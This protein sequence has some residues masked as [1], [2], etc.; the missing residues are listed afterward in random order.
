MEVMRLKFAVIGGDRRAALLAGLLLREGE[1]VQSFALEKAALPPE[2]PR[3]SSPEAALYGADAVLLPLPVERGGLLNAP[4]SAQLC[5]T[6]ELFELLWPGQ[7][8]CGGLIPASLTG[9]AAQRGL[10]PVDWMRRSAFVTGNAALTAEGAVGL[11]LQESEK[12]LCG[13]RVLVSGF[14][15]I[16]RL[17]A[18]KLRALGARVTVAA[19]RPEARAEAEA[20][21]CEALPFGALQGSFDY[22][23]NTVP[24]RV[25]END[26]LCCLPEGALLLELASAPGGYDRELAENLGL[27]CLAAPG[28]PGRSAPQ[29]AAELL[30]RE[31]RAVLKE[32]RE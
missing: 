25:L 18:V 8:V 26:T 1:K 3:A 12:A 7:L 9:F 28:L 15:R 4:F 27:R 29:A 24:A 31:L 11:L 22:L 32:E 21:G 13:S 6:K 23:V 10:T 17:L 30:L 19:R 14:G 16:G 5:P 20:L 2:I